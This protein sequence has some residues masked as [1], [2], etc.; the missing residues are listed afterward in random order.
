MSPFSFHEPVL[1]SETVDALMTDPEGIYI[2]GTLGGGGHTGALLRRLGKNG[3]IYGI[4]QDPEALSQV[5]REMGADTRLHPVSGNFGFMDILLPRELRGLIQGILLDLGVSGHQ[6]DEANRGFSFRKDGPLDMRMGTMTNVTAE[7]IVN[8]YSLE[9]LT[10]LIYQYGEERHSRRIA[11]A[12]I[13]ARPLHTTG[14]LRRVVESVV[15][16]PH[17]LKSVARVFQAIRIEVNRELEMLEKGLQAGRNLL[18]TGGRFVVISYHSLEDRMVKHFFRSGNIKGNLGKDLFGNPLTDMEL[19]NKK[20]ITASAEE[21][22]HNPRA[23]SARMRV[24]VKIRERS[25]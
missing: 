14:E 6:I 25:V 9:E 24:G 15:G 11:G 16:G 21:V 13:K 22:E 20:V 8:Q 18:K 23:R 5:H 17:A 4:D 10:N 1:L 19:L 12:M 7:T 2:D 3:Q